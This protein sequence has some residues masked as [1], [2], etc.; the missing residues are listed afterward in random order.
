[1]PTADDE[2]E[3]PCVM[4][5]VNDGVYGSFTDAIIVPENLDLEVH[6]LK[7]R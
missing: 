4:Y 5:Y 1:M 3:G 7:V 6:T 2:S